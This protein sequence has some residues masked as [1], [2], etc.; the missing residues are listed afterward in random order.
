MASTMARIKTLGFLAVMMGLL[1]GAFVCAQQNPKRLILK[2]GSYQTATKW[3][4]RGN[5]IRYYSAE[6][7]AWEELPTE[8]VDWPATEKYNRDRDTERA[9]TMRQLTKGDDEDSTAFAAAG[10]RLPGGG[11][12]FLPA[13]SPNQPPPPQLTQKGDAPHPRT[14]GNHL[15]AAGPPPRLP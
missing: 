10:L 15:P 1:A 3:E 4:I 9:T 14:T 6:R 12:G 11:G 7:F 13:T 5:H 8:L 2:D